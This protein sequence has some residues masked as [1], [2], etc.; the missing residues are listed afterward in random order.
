MDFIL[1]SSSGSF[2]SLKFLAAQA[3]SRMQSE[4]VA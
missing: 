2:K 3:A 1:Y 4:A